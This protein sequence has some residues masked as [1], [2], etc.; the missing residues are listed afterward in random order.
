MEKD[1]DF[2]VGVNNKVVTTTEQ[3]IPQII[4]T[5]EGGVR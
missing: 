2:Y 5:L 4:K 1:S 3:V